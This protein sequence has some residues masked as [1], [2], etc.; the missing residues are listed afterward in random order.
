[1]ERVDT[2]ELLSPL[3]DEAMW[4]RRLARALLRDH[5]SEDLAQDALLE[6]GGLFHRRNAELA[7]EHGGE[8]LVLGE[9]AAA[10]P[11]QRVEPHQLLVRI[12][13]ERVDRH[14]PLRIL[15]PGAVLAAMGKR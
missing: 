6:R 12:L 2:N 8:V 4:V 15:D 7:A 14:Q 9:G 3:A 11:R 1:M 10:A 5:E 13:G